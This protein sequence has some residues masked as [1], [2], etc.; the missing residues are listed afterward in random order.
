MTDDALAE[1]LEAVTAAGLDPDRWADVPLIVTKHFPGTKVALLGQDRRARRSLGGHAGGFEDWAVPAYFEH[2]AAI[3]PW[4]GF[5]TQAAPMK[6]LASE[7]ELP[8][9]L[10]VETEF[11]QD[12]LRRVGDAECAIGTKFL[13]EADAFAM[14]SIHY[15]YIDRPRQEDRLSR[16]LR[17]AAPAFRASLMTNRALGA[18]T[19]REASLAAVLD[20]LDA[21]AFLVDG[22]AKIRAVNRSGT[23]LI[24]AGLLVGEGPAEHLRLSDAE[25]QSRLDI[26]LAAAAGSPEGQ[27]TMT[28]VDLQAAGRH[29]GARLTI[30]PVTLSGTGAVAPAWVH[31]PPSLALVIVK[32]RGRPEELDAARL[33]PLLGLTRAEARVAAR[34]AA[35]VSVEDIAGEIG[36]ARETVRTHLKRI[37]DKTGCR[38]Q[39]E[40]VAFVSR[41]VGRI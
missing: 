26:A 30:A 28:E 8:T 7:Q 37:F 41:A 10:L 4:T 33:M 31:V 29:H 12:W 5:W 16:L 34:I 9:R 36:I 24:E 17:I 3:N 25:A 35:G 39:A 19:L 38:R 22:R 1:L 2:Y 32:V 21:P 20:C 14:L 23:A 18:A 13:D 40:L 11:Y 27:R 15:G 6:V